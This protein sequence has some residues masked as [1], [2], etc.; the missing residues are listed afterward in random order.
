MEPHEV[1]DS[2]RALDPLNAE[3]VTIVLLLVLA[4]LAFTNMSSPR[5]WRLLAQAMF[6]MR[7]G[8]QTLREEIDL[9]DRTLIGLLLVA[10]AVIAMFLYQGS[11]LLGPEQAPTFLFL[12]AMVLALL[13]AQGILLRVLAGLAGTDKGITEFLST[14]LLLFILT[15]VSLL[16]VVALMAYHSAWRQGLLIAG[17]LVIVLLL[18]YR[19]IRGAWVG[20]SEGVPL[21]YLILYLCAAEVAP[22][23]LL[24]HAWSTSMS[25]S[26]TP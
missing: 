4:A 8:R 7:L 2:L 14:G 1:Q 3:W 18:L 20:L 15:G 19:W 24:V 9:Q 6:R 26:T 16:P 13:L 22:A 23:L 5:K 12:A 21:R 17:A 25:L 10:I 11:I